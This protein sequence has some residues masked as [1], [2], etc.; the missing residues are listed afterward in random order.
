MLTD[1]ST[2]VVIFSMKKNNAF[3]FFIMVKV[4]LNKKI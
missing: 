2:K 4:L 1:S 3:V